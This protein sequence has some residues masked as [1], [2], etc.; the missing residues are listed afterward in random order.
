MYDCAVSADWPEEQKLRLRVQIIDKYFGNLA[1][2]FGFRD[3]DHVSVRMEKC[4]EAFLKE[5]SGWMNAR[6]DE[7]V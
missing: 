5:Y 4:A 7:G 1:I 2:L 3:K 6:A